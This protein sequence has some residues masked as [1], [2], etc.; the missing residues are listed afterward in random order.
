MTTAELIQQTRARLAQLAIEIPAAQ[1]EWKASLLGEGDPVKLAKQ[2]DKLTSEQVV[3]TARLEVLEDRQR[4]ENA[5]TEDGAQRASAEAANA[6]VSTHAA[7]ARQLKDKA[8]ELSA[9]IAAAPSRD[10]F[11]ALA[12]GSG[13]HLDLIEVSS[14]PDFY[15]DANALK[16][17]L[18]KVSHVVAMPAAN[19]ASIRSDRTTR[20]MMA[21]MQPGQGR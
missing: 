1:A 5:Q 17:A 12:D 11:Y 3:E 7:W 18:E 16:Y 21:V 19:V 4:D 2:T 10:A 13:K 20:S 6:I 8:A 14:I 9:V 15:A